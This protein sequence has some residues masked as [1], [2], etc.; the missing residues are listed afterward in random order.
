V[1]IGISL[2]ASVLVTVIFLISADYVFFIT[3][4]QI[5]KKE[6][7]KTLLENQNAVIDFLALPAVALYQ[8]NE[9]VTWYEQNKEIKI[10]TNF[11]EVLS[12]KING[13]TALLSVIKDE[14]E[15]DL[16]DSFFQKT[17]KQQKQAQ[18]L[19]ESLSFTYLRSGPLF[20][21]PILTSSTL[22][23]RPYLLGMG[24]DYRQQALLP[25]EH[26]S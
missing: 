7:R 11:Y 26:C 13:D 20:I 9:Q 25:P 5:Q 17:E 15:N 24:Q 14:A 18:L 4:I 8:D 3:G 19:T 12:V 21:T 6:F 16:F 23:H 22:A 10:G 2:F 1:K